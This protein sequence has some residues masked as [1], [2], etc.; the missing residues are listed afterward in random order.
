MK[1]PLLKQKIRMENYSKRTE[2][3]ALAWLKEKLNLFT[4]EK[5]ACKWR[6]IK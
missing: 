3:T 1:K 2:K 5:L 6:P 4:I